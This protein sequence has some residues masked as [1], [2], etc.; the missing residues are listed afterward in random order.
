MDSL[1][2]FFPEPLTLDPA[3]ATEVLS[4]QYITQIFSGLVALTPTLE[5]VPELAETY[6]ISPDGK[7]YTFCLRPNANFHNGKQITAQDIKYS[8][9]RAAVTGSRTVLT[10]LGDIIG[11]KEVVDGKAT[12]IRGVEVV[13]ER[14]LRVTIDAPKVYFLAKLTHPVAFVVDRFN[15]QE[16]GE[17]WWL[18]PNG[19]GPFRLKEW[20]PGIIM[21]LERSPDYYRAPAKIPYIVFR[22]LGVSARHMYETGEVDV[23]FPV[24]EEIEEISQPDNPLAEE[25]KEVAQLSISFVGFNTTKPPFDDATVR[26]SFLLATDRE[27]LVKEVFKERVEIAHGFLPPGLP[28]HNPKLSP[29]PFDP[30]EAR[31]LLA[32][33]SYGEDLPLVVFVTA[34]Y[35]TVSPTIEAL[36]DMWQ[37]NLGVRVEVKLIAPEDYYYKLETEM[38]NL[39][40]YGWIADYPDPQNFLDV[41]FHSQA[42]NNV[43]KYTNSQVDLLL[44][45]ARVESD[46]QVRFE[47]YQE[48]EEI[49]RQDAAAIPLSFGREF[50]LIKPFIKRACSESPRAGGLSAGILHLSLI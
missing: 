2:L 45:K 15:V 32:R 44:E 20:Q 24:I 28:A 46:P 11:V 12:E 9:E 38:E 10:Y 50:V 1:R 29:I 49:L 34:G 7:V 27:R 47:L 22:H 39:Y 18:E 42:A 25:L 6:E 17:Q 5:L 23:A 21:A 26:R 30:E 37:E 31:R 8:W 43:G 3:Q 13:D 16:G 35:L 36:I 40:H 48:A 19:T 14:T 33:S 4:V 41:L